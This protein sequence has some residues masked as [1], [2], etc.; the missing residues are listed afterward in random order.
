MSTEQSLLQQ[1]NILRNSTTV[2]VGIGN[3]LKGDD[4]A[5]PLVCEQLKHAK[6][7]ADLI[8][9]GTVPENYIQPIIKKAPQNLL[10]IDAID[11]GATPGT[12]GIFEPEQLS[13]HV[14]STHSLSPRLFVDMVCQDISIDV[15]FVGIQPAQIQLGQSISQ[16]VSLAI[17]QLS[18]TLAEIFPPR[19]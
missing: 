13:S 15:Y 2:I 6:V 10:V 1:L 9:A 16:Q 17:K 4:G 5:G 8:D 12:I 18:Q 7:S 3:T 19:K 11:F 14:I